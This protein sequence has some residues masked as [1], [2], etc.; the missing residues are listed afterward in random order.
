MPDHLQEAIR[1]RDG[2]IVR[3][4][5]RAGA[6]PQALALAARNEANEAMILQL[7]STVRVQCVCVWGGGGRVEGHAR[8]DI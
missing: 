6:E 2:E 1:R 8:G 4:G 5:Q 7:N 3:L